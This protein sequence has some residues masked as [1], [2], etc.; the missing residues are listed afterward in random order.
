MNRIIKILLVAVLS[1]MPFSTSWAVQATPY[2]FEVTQPDGT[3]LTVYLRGGKVGHY[4]TTEDNYL[5][6]KDTDGFYKYAEMIGK[7]VVPTEVVARNIASRTAFEKAF[8]QQRKTTNEL[9]DLPRPQCV[10][11]ISAPQKSTGFPSV[12][13]PKSLVI[14]VNFS[15]KDFSVEDPQ[16]KYTDLLNKTGYSDNEGT[17]SARDYFIA[18]S[19]GKFAPDFVVVGPYDLPNSI[20]YYGGNDRGGNDMRATN[21]V[22]DACKAADED[23]DFTEYDVDRDGFIDNVF[24]YYAGYNEAE[25]ASDDTVWPHRW[26]V[27]SGTYGNYDGEATDVMFD[28]VQ[29][30][31]YACTSELRGRTGVNMCG[32]GTFA[33]EFGHVLGLPDYYQTNGSSGRTLG[34]WNIMDSGSYNNEGRT[35][36]VYSAYDRFF[37]DWLIPTELTEPMSVVLDP[38]N[39]TSSEVTENQAYL[40]ANEKH[41]MNGAA[42]DPAEFFIT[43]YRE[44]IGWDT[45]LPK[46]GMLIWHIDYDEDAWYRN[47]PNNY[48]ASYQTTNNHMRVYIQPLVGNLSSNGTA[49]QSGNFTPILWNKDTLKTEDGRVKDLTEITMHA[50]AT[51]TFKFMGG[52]VTG[53]NSVATSDFF[54]IS[55]DELLV[56]KESATDVVYVFDALGQLVYMNNEVTATLNVPCGQ[57][58][59]GRIYIVKAGNRVA[60]WCY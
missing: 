18:S 60:K 31:D 45:Y 24:I 54:N 34:E 5:L 50:D 27:V 23:V 48:G 12:G 11:H 13:S 41:N 30:Y 35:P 17:G 33:H 1:C 36:P 20:K 39:Q 26:M 42:P 40:I 46:A 2:P 44:Q 29:L 56:K 25:G 8:V 21:M 59:P 9:V 38:I 3:T 7:Q 15:N 16:V 14:L 47:E 52:V 37:L 55:K 49:F 10:A 19:G 51:M 32:I 58:T 4:H 28:G 22:V 6:K 57:F 43:E 53:L